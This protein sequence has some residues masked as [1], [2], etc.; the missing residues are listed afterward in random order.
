M[1]LAKKKIQKSV[2]ITFLMMSLMIINI[3]INIIMS[4]VFAVL[5]VVF[6]L[7]SRHRMNNLP[8]QVNL[9]VA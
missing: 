4:L 9:V 8:Y 1:N 2:T 5:G 3:P 7:T 6:L